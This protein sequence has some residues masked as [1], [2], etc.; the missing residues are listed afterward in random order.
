[1]LT[2][3][4]AWERGADTMIVFRRTMLVVIAALAVGAGFSSAASSTRAASQHWVGVWSA[5]P[6]DASPLL[7]SFS[8][9]TLRMIVAPHLGGSTLRLRLSNRF[10]AGAITLNRIDIALRARGAGIVPGSDRLVR[11]D[12]RTA[13]RIAAGRDVLSDPVPLRFRAFQ[14]LAVSVYVAGSIA[15]PT[16]HFTTR[17]T[18]YLT[19]PGTGDHASDAS[20]AAFTGT[21]AFAGFSTGWY[22]L[23]AVD[24]RAQ[25]AVGAVVTL[26]DS[27]TDGFE[28][29]N[30]ASV[31]DPVG[32]N[33]NG[34]YPDDLARRLLGAHRRLSVLNAGIGG[35][36]VLRSSSGVYG[37]SALARLQRD[38]LDQPGVRDVI[39]LEGINDIGMSPSATSAQIIAGLK[40][41]VAR[42]RRAGLH[43]LLGTLTPSGGTVT[44]AYG[45]SAANA[46]RERVNRWIRS[47]QTVDV[48]DFDKAVRNPKHPSQIDPPYDG[49]DHLHFSLAGYRAMAAAVNLAQ[50]H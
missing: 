42:L 28:G 12:H 18:N 8:D 40:H 50:L 34:R 2:R 48:V 30:V 3:A 5:S 13:V 29:K 19:P 17:Q 39:V 25:P 47:Q 37:P 46:E 45:D 43:V 7:P 36:R 1:M 31:E 49:S 44:P 33:A 15:H 41:I 6:S 22:F 26:G 16:E 4:D 14:E 9:R 38:V 27:I 24:V 20:G 10:G 23:D 11:F 32:V 21:T 35:N